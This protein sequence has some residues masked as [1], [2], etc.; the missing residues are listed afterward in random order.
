MLYSVLDS[1]VDSL[2]GLVMDSVI[3]EQLD[4]LDYE[5]LDSML[6]LPRCPPT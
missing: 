5:V 2:L 6:D 4:F 1:D 3:D